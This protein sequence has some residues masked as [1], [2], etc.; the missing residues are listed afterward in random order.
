MSREPGMEFDGLRVIV[1]GGASGIGAATASHLLRRGARVAV[2]DL[3]TDGVPAPALAI[4]CD[5]VDDASVRAAV[6]RA[7]QELG[8][9]DVVVNNAGIGAQGTVADN[10]D[11][12]WHRVFDVNV[13]GAVRVSRAALP[14]LRRSPSAAIVN[15]SS[16]AAT[17][18]LPARALYAATKGAVRALTMSMAADH[19][20]EGIRV[21]CV[22]PGTADT[23]WI[24]RLLSQAEDPAAERAALEARQPHGRLV[25]PGEVAAAIAYLAS[26]LAGST[27]GTELAVDG[28]MQALRLR[29]SG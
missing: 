1:T 19:L 2:L 8:G 22:N 25:D 29:Q 5:L 17:A 26:P 14:Y 9:I 23:P 3:S 20:P 4:R 24:N 27:T 18:G 11:A 12:E 28:G 16:I 7:A 6:E 10:D 13:V 15:T 21:N